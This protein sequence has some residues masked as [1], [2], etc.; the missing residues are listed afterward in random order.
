MKVDSDLYCQALKSTI[1]IFEKYHIYTNDKYYILSCYLLKI[2]QYP[3]FENPIFSH[4]KYTWKS[5][6]SA[7]PALTC[8]KAVFIYLFI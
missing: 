4:V 7:K 3:Q 8:T 6:V 2:L 1:Y 5:V